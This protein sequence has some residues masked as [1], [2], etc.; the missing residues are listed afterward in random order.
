MKLICSAFRHDMTEEI[1]TINTIRL[2]QNLIDS[3]LDVEICIGH[4]KGNKEISFLV[5][6]FPSL[7]H[8]KYTADNVIVNYGQA[9]CYFEYESE[10]YLIS[11]YMKTECI[12]W[13]T[14][15]PRLPDPA[16][17]SYTQLMSGEF[18]FTENA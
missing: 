17:E 18:I 14:I 1:S 8:L 4:Y 13:E 2:G 15:A 3:G 10:A 11:K 12:G 5:T 6:G 16:P 7:A 9:C